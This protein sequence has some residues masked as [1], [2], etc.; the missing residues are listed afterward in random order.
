MARKISAKVKKPV[1]T[2]S[3]QLTLSDLK[4]ITAGGSSFGGDTWQQIKWGKIGIGLQPIEARVA[5]KSVAAK[6]KAK[7]KKAT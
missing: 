7:A 5:K 4:K 1:A 6:A 2:L 3:L